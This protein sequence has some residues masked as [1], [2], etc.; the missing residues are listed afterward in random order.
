MQDS[1]YFYLGLAKLPVMLCY[2]FTK[3]QR[4]MNR[5]KQCWPA[6]PSLIVSSY[7][8]SLSKPHSATPK[9]QGVPIPITVLTQQSH[10]IFKKQFSGLEISPVFLFNDKFYSYIEN[11]FL[12]PDSCVVT[13]P[14]YQMFSEA[15][16]ERMGANGIEKH[17]VGYLE[18]YG[19]CKYGCAVSSLVSMTLYDTDGQMQWKWTKQQ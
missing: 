9:F 6:I 17:A 5:L 3:F 8:I 7:A 13:V 16:E 12:W 14:V 15:E 18:I 2:F 1:R 11:G 19:S 4:K 10:P